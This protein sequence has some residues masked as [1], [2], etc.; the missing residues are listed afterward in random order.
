MCIVIFLDDGWATVQ[1]RQNCSITAQ[2]VRKD[3]YSA[4]FIINLRNIGVPNHNLNCKID[5]QPQGR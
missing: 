1:D 5:Y 4:G 3:L 2:A